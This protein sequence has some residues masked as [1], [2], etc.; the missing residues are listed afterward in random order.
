MREKRNTTF[1]V[2]FFFALKACLP[3]TIV[4]VMVNSRWWALEKFD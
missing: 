4:D 2:V 1:L 3:E